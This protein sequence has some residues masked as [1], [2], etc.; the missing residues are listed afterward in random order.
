MTILH[1]LAIMSCAVWIGSHLI[2]PHGVMRSS[3]AGDVIGR[4]LHL[5]SACYVF[6]YLISGGV[7]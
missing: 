5:V 2:G 7:R 6:W 4:G 3:D 1:Y